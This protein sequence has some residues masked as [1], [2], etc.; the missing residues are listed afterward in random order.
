MRAKEWMTM[1]REPIICPYCG[2]GF[3]PKNCRQVACGGEDCKNAKQREYEKTPYKKGYW[4][5]E[6]SSRRASMRKY[7]QSPKRKEMKREYRQMPE[8]KESRRKYQVEYRKRP[9]A[10]ESRRKYQREYEKRPEAKERKRNRDMKRYYE[11]K[12]VEKFWIMAKL[13]IENKTILGR[14]KENEQ[15]V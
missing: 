14:I 7:E 11:L 6:Q 2:V 1:A 10:K 9:E 15:S 12:R 13:K 8:T 5:Y 3:V 4:K